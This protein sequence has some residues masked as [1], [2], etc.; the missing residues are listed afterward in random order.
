MTAYQTLVAAGG[1][2]TMESIPRDGSE[3]RELLRL[4]AW[5]QRVQ[6]AGQC[7]KL[8]ADDVPL[9]GEP[10][11]T[12]KGDELSSRIQ[13][14][15]G[16]YE[17]VDPCPLS[18]EASP[19]SN[20]ETLS[21]P[22]QGQSNMEKSVKGAFNQNQKG[23]FSN[24]YFQSTNMSNGYSSSPTHQEG[25]TTSSKSPSPC[26]LS[27][28]AGQQK[29]TEVL[30]ELRE[31][32]GLL[33]EMPPEVKPLPFPHSSD[34]NNTD[35]DTRET[36]NTQGCTGQISESVSIMDVS[37][38]NTKQSPKEMV[39]QGNKT[40]TLPSQTFPSLLSHK[41]PSIIMTQKPTA[42]V[43]PMDGQ[44]QVVSDSP[45]LKPLLEPL[46]K[47]IN[48]PDQ[49]KMSINLQFWE[50]K[51]GETQ[52]VEDIL[53]EMAHPCPPPLTAIH[54]PCTNEVSK[55][56]FP[57]REAEH[58]SS[59]PEQNNHDLPHTDSS[60]PKRKGS[61]SSCEVAHSS[62]VESMSSSDTDSSSAS[63]SESET[64]TEE[65]PQSSAG[66]S[67]K[68][69]PGSPAM[70][71]GDWQ[72]GNW[73]RSSQQSSSTEIQSGPHVSQ[74]LQP[75]QST[76]GSEEV[77]CLEESKPLLSSNGAE[78]TDKHVLLH[79]CKSESPQDNHCQKSSQKSLFAEMKRC[80]SFTKPSKPVKIEFED[81]TETANHVKVEQ[82]DPCFIDRPKVKTKTRHPKKRKDSSEAKRD[83]K[84]TKLS[85][86]DRQK[87]KAKAAPESQPETPNVTNGHC[88][89]PSLSHTDLPS[90]ATPVTISC[91][92]PKA[93]KIRHKTVPSK[94]NHKRLKKLGH[95]AKRSLKPH[96]PPLMVK[97]DLHMLS[98]VPQTSK[99][100][101]GIPRL[102][103]KQDDGSVDST[104]AQKQT[105]NSKS[106]RHQS[107]EVDKIPKKKQKLENQDASSANVSI[108]LKSSSKSAEA[109]EKE[110]SK[111]KLQHPSTS[112]HATT[113]SKVDKNCKEKTRE[114]NKEA[115]KNKDPHKHEKSG[116]KHREP[117]HSEKHKQLKN[118][119]TVP[120]KS[121]SAAE[122]PTSR[123]LL[124]FEETQYPVKHYIKE[125]KRLK[126]KAD[127]ESD[128]LSKA[129]TYL[130]AAMFFVESG[131]A[132]EKDPQVSLSSYTMFAETVELLKFVLKLKNPVDPSSLASEKDF[133][134][135]CLKCQALL[136]M[137]IF[138]HK[139][140]TALKYSRT[141]TDH[142]NVALNPT[143]SSSKAPDNPPPSHINTSIN[144]NHSEGSSTTG[145]TVTVPQT[146]GKMT[147]AFVNITSL[148]LSAHDMW[149]QAEEMA[150]K[151]SGVLAELD[152]VMGPLCLT[153][154][155]SAMVRY[156]RQGICWLRR[157]GQKV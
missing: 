56:Q 64:S 43:R 67:V 15:L 63:E 132:M 36:L 80:S 129:F 2:G 109:R 141:L 107:D 38:L 3:E 76:K 45:E 155:M 4:Q 147:L 101:Q 90:P 28:S 146:V 157:E 7:E 72:L 25:P 108:K 89:T 52:C 124:R 46:P 74:Q 143:V 37:T 116:R 110:K 58:V 35:R 94:T 103:V 92:K 31:P 106:S 21:Q 153:S 79:Q 60:L 122:A 88:P 51:P 111:K 84:R 77:D 48:K 98:R 148:F 112:K 151:G 85:S 11:K 20:Y 100:H 61:S 13:R 34:H 50:T 42:Y 68:T 62:G 66:S 87:A 128:K 73:I 115:V 82:K 26:Q 27:H 95:A 24:S 78:V 30:S 126:H 1:G 134:V 86:P 119:T 32:I 93:E 6:E 53:R 71:H 133:L 154:S 145:T 123:P 65:R 139:H 97:I 49:G 118:R 57:A 39:V 149:E 18:T 83:F 75:T 41:Q 135:L 99:M 47:L 150:H 55:C 137:T 23:P 17:N 91:S 114:S 14:M 12:N 152:T 105:K 104:A 40:N 140:K 70:S 120:S 96:R 117:P 113:D 69:K 102:V 125:A 19:T 29:N 22:D 144:S 138:H 130:D 59:C 16:S 33:Q 127:A 54:S 156:T 9:F 142:F 121:E 44:D 81:H 131:I 8:K 10:Y 136:Q 5:A